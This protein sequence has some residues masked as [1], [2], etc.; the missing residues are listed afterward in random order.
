MRDY[1]IACAYAALGVMILAA[2]LAAS[3][4]ELAKRLD[5]QDV[6]IAQV[7]AR[8]AAIE[9]MGARI[10][11]DVRGVQAVTKNHGDVIWRLSRDVAALRPQVKRALRGRF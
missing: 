7:E 2:A 3:D 5:D 11:K 9:K 10:E 4:R 1:A 6:R 8:V